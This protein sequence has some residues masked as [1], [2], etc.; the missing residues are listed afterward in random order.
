MITKYAANIFSSIL[1]GAR[2]A[3]SGAGAALGSAAAVGFPVY[4]YMSGDDSMGG[5]AGSVA[6]MAAGT[7]AGKAIGQQ[8]GRVGP[9]RQMRGFGAGLTRAGNAMLRAKGGGA[10]ATIGRF[11]G[12]HALKAAGGLSRFPGKSL[13]TVGALGGGIFGFEAGRNIGNKYVP[14]HQRDP[15]PQVKQA[16]AVNIAKPILSPLWKKRFKWTGGIA[17]TGLAAY[18][19]NKNFNEKRN[20][21]ASIPQYQPMYPQQ[22]YNAK[23]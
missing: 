7:V 10:L 14:I 3:G 16:S 13:G 1:N 9:M 11:I 15:M 17:G 5:A 8:L 6:G 21:L 12:G 19:G 4:Q 18:Y 20:E 22:F 23:Q 2:K